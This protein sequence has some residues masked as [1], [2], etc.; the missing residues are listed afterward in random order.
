LSLVQLVLDR[1]RVR[2]GGEVGRD[3]LPDTREA[4]P[5]SRIVPDV[6]ARDQLVDDVEVPFR[7]NPAQVV[8]GGW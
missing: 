4:A 3:E 6:P 7:R 2:K 8:R 5:D 1:D